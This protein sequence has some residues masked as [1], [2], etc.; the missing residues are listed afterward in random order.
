MNWRDCLKAIVLCLVLWPPSLAADEGGIVEAVV[1]GKLQTY[2]FLESA[3]KRWRL[4]AL[5]PQAKDH[6][7]WD[8]AWGVVEQARRENVDVGAYQAG[9]YENLEVQRRQIQTCIDDKSDAILLAAINPNAFASEQ[10]ELASRGIKL[11]DLVNG[12]NGSQ[13]AAHSHL[14]FAENAKVG[15][16]FALRLATSQSK[17]IAWF[18]GPQGADWSTEFDRVVH[19]SIPGGGPGKPVLVE[20][21][22][23]PT[24]M[25]AQAS[26]VRRLD[27]ATKP[28]IILANA[29]AAA[30]AARFY[31]HRSVRPKIISLYSNDEAIEALREGEMTAMVVSSPADQA[32]IAVDLAVRVLEHMTVPNLVSIPSRLITATEIEAFMRSD[33]RQGTRIPLPFLPPT[34]N[35]H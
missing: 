28:D 30:F 10:E 3:S 27:E 13:I 16:Q 19:D 24:D 14:G 4:C 26:L 8:V 9:G 15:V 35:A 12:L 18:P 23:G 25:S 21:G 11:I 32:R 33:E 5:L 17:R 2:S 7:F 6:F 34:G 1:D 29:V 22:W 31:A 20:G